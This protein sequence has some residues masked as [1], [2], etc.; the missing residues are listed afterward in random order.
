MTRDSLPDLLLRNGKPRIDLTML[1]PPF[2]ARLCMALVAA[3]KRDADY[4]PTCGWRSYEEQAK[5]YAAYQKG[6]GTRAAPPGH[7]AHNFGGAVDLAPD[8]DLVKP[9]L[10]ADYRPRM[11]KTLGEEVKRVGLVWGDS[12]N[13]M[14]HVQ[15]P[16]YVSGKQLRPLREIYVTTPG[17][18]KARLKA[19]WDYLDAHLRWTAL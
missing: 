8:G 4:Y 13:D 15:I 5:R 14:P 9:G 19:V 6:E 12:F 7:S 11:Y 10:Q 18:P 17:D 1:W 16:V 3:Q 2:V